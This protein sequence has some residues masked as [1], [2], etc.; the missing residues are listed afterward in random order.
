MIAGSCLMNTRYNKHGR[1]G[2]RDV[3][4]GEKGSPLQTPLLDHTVRFWQHP[5]SSTDCVVVLLSKLLIAINN[6]PI[7]GILF[8]LNNTSSNERA[9]ILLIA[10]RDTQLCPVNFEHTQQIRNPL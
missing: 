4:G 5:A 8:F 7:N 3:G 10:S 9:A 2:Q 1:D 6:I